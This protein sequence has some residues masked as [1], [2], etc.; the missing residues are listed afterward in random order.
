MCLFL[1]FLTYVF[2]CV[3]VG[4]LQHSLWTTFRSNFSPSS[5]CA[6]DIKHRLSSAAVAPFA[7]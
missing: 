2:V 4:M 6:P 1:S 7:H 3:A 5:M